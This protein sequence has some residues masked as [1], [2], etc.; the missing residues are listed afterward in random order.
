MDIAEV[1]SMKKFTEEHKNTHHEGGTTGQG[2]GSD[3]EGEEDPRGGQ[4][5]KC[6]Q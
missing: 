3:E 1:C 2:Y 4:R 6:N 5:V